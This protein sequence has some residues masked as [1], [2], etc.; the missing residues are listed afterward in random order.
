MTFFLFSF[1]N[2]TI[3]SPKVLGWTI[4]IVW[5]ACGSGGKWC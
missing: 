1:S 2:T 4:T 3:S 5:P